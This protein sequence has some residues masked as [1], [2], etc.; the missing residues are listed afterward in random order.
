MSNTCGPDKS[1][2]RWCDMPWTTIFASTMP[3]VFVDRVFRYLHMNYDLET[4]RRDGKLT[5]QDGSVDGKVYDVKATGMKILKVRIHGEPYLAHRLV[6]LF[7]HGEWPPNNLEF[8][9]GNGCNCAIENLRLKN[10][11]A[12]KRKGIA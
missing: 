8:I 2:E 10:R 4:A 5:R 12:N 1:Q 11:T 3:E 7:V 6:W 9:D